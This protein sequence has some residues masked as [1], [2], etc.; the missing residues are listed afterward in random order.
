VAV[1]TVETFPQIVESTCTDLSVGE[2]GGQPPFGNEATQGI[3]MHCGNCKASCGINSKCTAGKCVCDA[4]FNIPCVGLSQGYGPVSANLT[5]SYNWGGYTTTFCVANFN[6]NGFCGSCFSSCG[7]GSS[8]INQVC[9]CDNPANGLCK[10]GGY[11]FCADF[12]TSA[13]HCGKCFSPCPA[14]S[15][16]VAGKCQCPAG[17]TICS[18]KSGTDWVNRCFNLQNNPDRCGACDVR[19]GPGVNCVNGVCSCGAGLTPCSNPDLVIDTMQVKTC[20]NT[21]SDPG[22]C[23]TCGN[24]CTTQ[25]ICDAGQYIFVDKTKCPER[26]RITLASTR[27]IPEYCED[28]CGDNVCRDDQLCDSSTANEPQCI[29]FDGTSNSTP[30]PIP[31]LTPSPTPSPTPSTAPGQQ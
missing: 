4:G 29:Y 7:T 26:R 15:A 17:Q 22:N 8:C 10:K 3:R 24:K 2:A 27:T 14:G 5:G 30:T 6:S 31:S 12:T 1:G 23:G 9:R 28:I 25:Q 20:V 21:S 11:S 19:C 16:C 18:D 13:T